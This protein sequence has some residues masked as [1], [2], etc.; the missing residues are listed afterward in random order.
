M[1]D[2]LDKF[3]QFAAHIRA[4]QELSD[5]VDSLQAGLIMLGIPSILAIKFGEVMWSVVQLAFTCGEQAA[6]DSIKERLTAAKIEAEG[7]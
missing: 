4:N 7:H 1:N 2:D 5:S 3:A 6:V